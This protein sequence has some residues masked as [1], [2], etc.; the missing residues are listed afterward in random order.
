MSPPLWWGNNEDF[1]V[2]VLGTLGG[3][4]GEPALLLGT[5]FPHLQGCL[6][7]TV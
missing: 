5:Q 2:Q 1:C 3:S 7:G 4:Q 6:A